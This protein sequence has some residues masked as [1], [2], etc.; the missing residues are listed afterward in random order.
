MSELSKNNG[1]SMSDEVA[2][3]CEQEELFSVDQAAQAE[4]F[5]LMY[6]KTGDTDYE[7][8]RVEA[9]ERARQQNIIFEE[10]V[11]LELLLD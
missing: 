8:M 3:R 2:R 9:E 6:E 1:L 5:A 11:K 10:I 7:L 4:G